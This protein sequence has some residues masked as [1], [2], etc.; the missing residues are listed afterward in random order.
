MS[1]EAMLKLAEGRATEGVGFVA[2]EGQGV[3]EIE[4]WGKL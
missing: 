4:R 2:N 1:G 3:E